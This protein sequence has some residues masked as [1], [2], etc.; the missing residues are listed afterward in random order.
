MI[1]NLPFLSFCLFVFLFACLMFALD[2]YVT[3]MKRV[4]DV[5]RSTREKTWE[6]FG[7]LL[8][9]VVCCCCAHFVNVNTFGRKMLVEWAGGRAGGTGE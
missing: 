7:L 9:L 4:V 2:Q 8:L 6:G 3:W 5:A 1:A